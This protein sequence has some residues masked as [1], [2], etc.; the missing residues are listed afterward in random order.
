MLYNVEFSSQYLGSLKWL[1][2][3]DVGWLYLSNKINN[4]KKLKIKLT[5]SSNTTKYK[6]VVTQRL[7]SQKFAINAKVR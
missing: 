2:S 6:A 3:L 7:W 1:T 4:I 5:L